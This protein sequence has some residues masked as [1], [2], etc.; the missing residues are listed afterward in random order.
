MTN[1]C[2]N[3]IKIEKCPTRTRIAYQKLSEWIGFVGESCGWNHGFYMFLQANKGDPENVQKASGGVLGGYDTVW[4]NIGARTNFQRT[5]RL[6]ARTVVQFI[7]PKCGWFFE[8]SITLDLSCHAIIFV[9]LFQDLLGYES[10]PWYPDGTLSWFM[11]VYSCRT[12]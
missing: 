9:T 12:W 2:L 3:N 1:N 10:K 8:I 11:D 6:G 5:L 7:C 4:D